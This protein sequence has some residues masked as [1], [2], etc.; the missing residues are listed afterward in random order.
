MNLERWEERQNLTSN[1][2]PR[3]PVLAPE[4]PGRT[5]LWEGRFRRFWGFARW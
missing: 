2:S 3:L 5:V 1:A 4:Q